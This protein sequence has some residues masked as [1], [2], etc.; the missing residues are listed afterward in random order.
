MPSKDKEALPRLARASLSV[1][2]ASPM[3]ETPICAA[4]CCSTM[5]GHT[6][7]APMSI[8]SRR[9]KLTYRWCVFLG[10]MFLSAVRRVQGALERRSH[11]RTQPS[12]HHEFIPMGL[13]P[14]LGWLSPGFLSYW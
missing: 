12:R 11:A 7:V 14:L 13:G 10:L 5:L 4:S 6:I 1:A 2:V 3:L 9:H 8:A